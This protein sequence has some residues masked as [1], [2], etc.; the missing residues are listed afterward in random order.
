M[1]L[2]LNHLETG[3]DGK[4]LCKYCDK[5]QYLRTQDSTYEVKKF[6]HFPVTSGNN[7]SVVEG[8]VYFDTR[9]FQESN[10]PFEGYVEGNIKEIILDGNK[11][12][13]EKDSDLFFRQRL[14]I[15]IS[16]N[17]IPVEIVDKSGKTKKSWVVI[18]TVS[19]NKAPL[20]ED[21]IAITTN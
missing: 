4:K 3:N 18:E 20:I 21:N 6:I 1:P 2:V 13:F 14:D 9:H 10:I 15:F 7:L 8:C 12:N 16:Y 17:K 11:V 5:E 19:A